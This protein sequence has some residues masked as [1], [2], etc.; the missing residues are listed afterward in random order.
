MELAIINGTYRDSSQRNSQSRDCIDLQSLSNFVPLTV[1][2]CMQLGLDPDQLHKL[3]Q[4]PVALTTPLRHAHSTPLGAP[5]IISSRQFSVPTST[6][7]LFNGSGPPPLITPADASL[8]YA[9]Y[10]DFQQYAALTSQ[11]LLADYPTTHTGTAVIDSLTSTGGLYV[12][13]R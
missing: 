3:T 4:I 12:N 8:L 10:A 5:L 1:E 6:A 11:S 2:Q 13:T 7:H 9:P